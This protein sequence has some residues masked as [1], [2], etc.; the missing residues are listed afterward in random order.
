MSDD[1]YEKAKTSFT[2]TLL[3]PKEDAV[4]ES[5]KYSTYLTDSS[6]DFAQDYRFIAAA[7]S[8]SKEE[9]IARMAAFWSGSQNSSSNTV[10]EDTTSSTNYP[11]GRRCV[12]R[13]FPQSAKNLMHQTCRETEDVISEQSSENVQ[14]VSNR[15]KALPQTTPYVFVDDIPMFKLGL[16]TIPSRKFC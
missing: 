15:P 8:L 2:S 16:E 1:E 3:R 12:L 11:V 5:M 4:S 14:A 10:S 6:Y 9:F 13:I 7:Q